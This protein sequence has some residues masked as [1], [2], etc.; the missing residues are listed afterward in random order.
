MINEKRKTDGSMLS[1]EAPPCDLFP[2]GRLR[3][4][5]G[6]R[7]NLDLLDL[8]RENTANHVLTQ[9]GKR[10]ITIGLPLCR[11]PY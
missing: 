9:L 11:T 3:A 5:N 2:S 6:N 7:R 4:Q 8:H 1:T 10:L